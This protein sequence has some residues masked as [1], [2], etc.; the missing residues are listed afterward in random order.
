MV[1]KDKTNGIIN[2]LKQVIFNAVVFFVLMAVTFWVVFKDQDLNDVL[3]I[4]GQANTLFILCGLL[5]M[6]GYFS[7]EAWNIKTLLNSFGEK[8][9]F[10]SALKYTLI[11]F[12]F[13]AITPGASGGQ[14]LEVYYMTKDKIS[15]G[16]AT[17]AILIQT[18]GVQFAVMALGILCAIIGH[19]LLDGVVFWLFLLGLLING[20]ALIVLALCVFFPDGLQRV[21]NRFLRFL[22]KRGLK[23]AEKWQKGLENGLKQYKDSSRYIKSHKKEFIFSLAKVFVQMVLF[24]LIPL[25]VYLAFGLSGTSL[26]TIFIMQSILFVATSGLPIPGAIGASEGVFLSLYGAVFGESLRS[27]LV[28]SRGISFYLFVLV[29]MIVVFINL[30]ILNHRNKK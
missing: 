14:P 17:I 24:F 22:S 26:F 11:G 23:A 7:M 18:C 4:L 6:F 10:I 12:F 1:K 19:N 8:V 13:C 9:N 21:V 28:L 16:N 3:A 27:A 15:G 25:F 30:T 2:T 20:V 29:S 5:C